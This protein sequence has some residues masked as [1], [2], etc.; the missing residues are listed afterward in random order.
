MRAAMEVCSSTSF[1]PSTGARAMP[2][3]PP[4]RIGPRAS[5]LVAHR[6]RP[7]QDELY[8]KFP[9]IPCERIRSI[10]L[11]YGEN[12]QISNSRDVQVHI[13]LKRKNHHQQQR[14]EHCSYN[15]SGATWDS[16]QL[17]YITVFNPSSETFASHTGGALSLSDGLLFNMLGS[18]LKEKS[19]RD[20]LQ[21]QNRVQ[22]F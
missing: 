3:P 17:F 13:L 10:S 5:A 7:S 2:P 6:P 22:W 21:T 9:S 14:Q 19:D 15:L 11:A 4:P 8:V 16:F 18:Y 1:P 20:S 12:A